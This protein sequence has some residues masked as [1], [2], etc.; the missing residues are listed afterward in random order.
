MVENISFKF[1]FKVV[2]LGLAPAYLMKIGL[3]KIS[4]VMLSKLLCHWVFKI[5]VLTSFC[6]LV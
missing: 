3:Q 2:L 4:K 1:C 5:I 6:V